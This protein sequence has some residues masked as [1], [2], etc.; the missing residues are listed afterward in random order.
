MHYIY[1]FYFF[2]DHIC[3]FLKWFPDIWK[4]QVDFC[5]LAGEMR[6]L[7]KY[8]L[9]LQSAYDCNIKGASRNVLYSYLIRHYFALFSKLFLFKRN[10]TVKSPF[11]IRWLSILWKSYV[12]FKCRRL[13]I[14]SSLWGKS[15]Y[16]VYV[17]QGSNTKLQIPK[18][19][20]NILTTWTT[21]GIYLF[22]VYLRH[23]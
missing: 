7:G 14:N 8:L 12:Q 20:G 16:K 10:G 2:L 19:S 6:H 3:I 18:N 5:I 1:C 15:I 23:L 21:T 4:R 9:K 13:A 11:E 22:V 17:T